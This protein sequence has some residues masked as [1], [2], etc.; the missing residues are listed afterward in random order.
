[1][2]LYLIEGVYYG[3]QAEAKTAAKE[4]GGKFDAEG[5]QV[6]VPTDKQGLIDYLNELSHPIANGDQFTDVYVRHDPP[7][8]REVIRDNPLQYDDAWDQFPLAKKLHF[9]SLALEEARD[10]ANQLSKQARD[11]A[12]FADAT[13][14]NDELFS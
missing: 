11:D 12:H 9:A 6:E 8:E 2:K 3:T 7:V 4:L 5:A 10:A 13:G 1:M 14:E